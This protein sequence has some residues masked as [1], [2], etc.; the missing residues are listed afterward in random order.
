VTVLI[1]PGNAGD[2]VLRAPL[3]EALRQRG[4]SV[5]LLDDRGYN[6]NP[7]RPDQGGAGARRSGRAGS[8]SKTC[9]SSPTS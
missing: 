9:G 6:A 1:A 4:L 3:T 2:R 7:R 8:S 5:L